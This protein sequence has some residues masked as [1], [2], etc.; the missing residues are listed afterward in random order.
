MMM[1]PLLTFLLALNLTQA[2]HYLVET[3]NKK[4]HQV[5]A[6]IPVQF[7]NET[8]EEHKSPPRSNTKVLPKEARRRY[9]SLNETAPKSLQM[10]VHEKY[11]NDIEAVR[12][13]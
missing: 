13:I 9:S 2:K 6:V 5:D 10:K 4:G 8:K 11:G 3:A 7:P 12:Y 1:L